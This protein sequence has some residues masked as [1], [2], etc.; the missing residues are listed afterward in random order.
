MGRPRGYDED[1]VLT[2]AMHAFRRSGYAGVSVRELETATSLSAGS[3]YHAYGGKAELFDTAFR[4]YNT[5]VLQRRIDRY[6]PPGSGPKGLRELFRSMLHEPDGR[7]SGCLITNSAVEFGSDAVHPQVSEGFAVLERTFAA[8]LE[9]SVG[10][11]W[12]QKRRRSAATR[13][14]AL[15]QGV[16]VLVRGG[17]D[18]AAVDAM[19]VS[20]FDGLTRSGR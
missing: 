20:E 15:Y 10:K 3:L 12:S 17:Y 5:S 4:H 14:L 19:V 2:G 8:R 18:L 1:S 16:L 13:L 9:E 6:A 11:S 7:R